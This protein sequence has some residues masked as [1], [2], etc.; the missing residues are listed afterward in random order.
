MV[1]ASS[2]GGV[3]IGEGSAILVLEDLDSAIQRKA[4]IYAE[5]LGYGAGLGLKEGF[6]Q[7][8]QDCIRESKLST[9]DIDCISSGANSDSAND[10]AEAQAIK[11]L[12]SDQGELSVSYI[13]K[14]V[15][16]CYSAT[17]SLQAVAAI[18]EITQK[19]A[20][21]VLANAFGPNSSNSSLMISKFKG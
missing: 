5:V 3:I 20:R 19:N 6:M 11:D 21:N 17:G 7:S 1:G 14:L 10:L 15:G 16:E 8:I 9:A 13:K 12:F 2:N 18:A 4:P